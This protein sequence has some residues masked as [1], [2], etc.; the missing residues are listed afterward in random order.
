MKISL[1]VP[2][3]DAL[4]TP[5]FLRTILM[6]N[7]AIFPAHIHSWGE[8][9]YSHNGVVQVMVEQKRYLVPP[10]Y[11][12]WLPPNM[13]HLGLNRREVLQSSL[14]VA[15][16]L[17][18]ALPRQPQALMVSPFMRSVLNH[19]RESALNYAD[20]RHLR[21]LTV[22][23]DELTETPRAGTF[24][25]ASDDAVLGKTLHYLE[26]HPNDNRS[27]AELAREAHITERTLARKCRQDLGMPLTEWRN[28][29]RVVS[30][31]AMIEEGKS[32]ES[33]A[34]EFGYSSASAFIVMF[35]KLSGAT[36]ASYR[37]NV[38]EN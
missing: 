28:R 8:F 29:M 18:G 15:N 27:V 21:L 10:Q 34:S 24:L 33:I 14:Y 1:Q 35:K 11:G 31:I 13:Q 22:F 17:C 6:P 26:N 19:A 20:K 25:P 5:L 30:A 7:D 2:F 9:V 12:I 37:E 23:L 38:N 32:V 16:E 36:P 3:T 4:P